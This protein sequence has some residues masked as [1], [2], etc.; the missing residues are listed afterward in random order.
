MREGEIWNGSESARYISDEGERADS[1]CSA[2]LMLGHFKLQ[3]K[4]L[5]TRL[6]QFDSSSSGRRLPRSGLHTPTGATVHAMMD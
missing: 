4:M 1:I 2:V 3:R 5:N 6:P